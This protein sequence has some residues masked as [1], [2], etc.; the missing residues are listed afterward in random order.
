MRIV[1]ADI[2]GQRGF[3]QKDVVVGGYGARLS[4]FSTL[5]KIA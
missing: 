1:L 5:T 4:G 2:K 3:V